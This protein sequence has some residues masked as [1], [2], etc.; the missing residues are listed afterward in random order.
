MTLPEFTQPHHHE[1][2]RARLQTI[3]AM[4]PARKLEIATALYWS[5]REL[6]A[7]GLR[8][9]HPE[10]PEEQVQAEVRSIFLHA[11]P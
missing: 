11:R 10:W 4:S 9:S 8:R 7:A 5:A 1:V 2:E 6:K 3:K